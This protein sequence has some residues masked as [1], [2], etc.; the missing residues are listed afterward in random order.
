M[1]EADLAFQASLVPEECI[2]QGFIAV[3]SFLAPDGSQCWRTYNQLDVPLSSVLG[4]LE[5]AKLAK[6]D[7]I[8]RVDSG[9]P[10]R[11]VDDGD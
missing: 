2:P 9:L 10:I 4:L 8:A 6:L 7:A 5:L 11:Y 1:D 3:F